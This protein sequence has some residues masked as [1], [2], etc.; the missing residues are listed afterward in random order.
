MERHQRQ[1]KKCLD[2]DSNRDPTAYAVDCSTVEL[3]RPRTVS[4]ARGD[5]NH[6]T[7]AWG[8]PH[9]HDLSF[10]RFLDVTIFLP[11]SDQFISAIVWGSDRVGPVEEAEK[12][13]V[14]SLWRTRS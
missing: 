3:L 10:H 4:R 8:S 7:S 2:P 14:A 11:Y 5:L 12:A 1:W 6:L 13:E 9:R